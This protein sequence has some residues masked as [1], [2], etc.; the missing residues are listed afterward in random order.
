MS[1]FM[2]LENRMSDG[3]SGTRGACSFLWTAPE[4][5]PDRQQLNT[6]WNRFASLSIKL[7]TS[8]SAD[9]TDIKR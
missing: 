6:Q 2:F 5:T 3:L 1:E 4:P 9:P 7:K 8:G